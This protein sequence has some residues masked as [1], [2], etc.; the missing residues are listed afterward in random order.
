MLNAEKHHLGRIK[1]L[2]C[3]VCGDQN[4][5]HAHHIKEGDRRVSHFATIPLCQDCHQ[6]NHNGIHGA[7]AMWK[8]MKKTELLVLAETIEKLTK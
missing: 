3:G 6:D 7:K 1:Q 4:I 5:S 8:V 2:P